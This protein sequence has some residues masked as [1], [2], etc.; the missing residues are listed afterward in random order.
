LSGEQQIGDLLIGA[1]LN[2]SNWLMNGLLQLGTP[3]LQQADLVIQENRRRTDC[4]WRI[5]SC[6]SRSASCRSQ[7]DDGLQYIPSRCRVTD[8]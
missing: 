5:R 7:H 3:A 8:R 4:E 2:K 1:A 6:D